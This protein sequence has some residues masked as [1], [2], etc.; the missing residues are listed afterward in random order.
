MGYN[1]D[2]NVRI[3]RFNGIWTE[4][5]ISI[6]GLLKIVVEHR[7]ASEFVSCIL[8]P[9]SKHKLNSAQECYNYLLHMNSK[10]H[11]P[12]NSE[13]VIARSMLFTPPSLFLITSLFSS[14]SPTVALNGVFYIQTMSR[15]FLY[16]MYPLNQIYS[17]ILWVSCYRFLSWLVWI[18]QLQL[19]TS[20]DYIYKHFYIIIIIGFLISL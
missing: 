7:G 1:L 20:I 13:F 15:S 18:N 9:I 4:H 11:E 10:F 14:C 5:A 17:V 16:H 3:L 19:S 12:S 6:T 8:Y 2:P